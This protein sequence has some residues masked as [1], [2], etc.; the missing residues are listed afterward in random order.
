MAILVKTVTVGK[1]ARY[2]YTDETWDCSKSE[3]VGNVFV[4]GC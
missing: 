1:L 2:M 4:T 3:M